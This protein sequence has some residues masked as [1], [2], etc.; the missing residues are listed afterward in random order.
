MIFRSKRETARWAVFLAALVC[1]MSAWSEEILVINAA[2]NKA[3]CKSTSV[4]IGENQVKSELCVSQGSFSHDKYILKLN[5]EAA[6][7]GIDDQ[8]TSGIKSSYKGQQVM[9]LCPP[10]N[11]R[12][13]V[14]AEEI[15]KLVPSYSS[16]K[17]KE[18]A[19]LLAG[20]SMPIEVGRLCQ[21]TIENEAVMKVQVLFE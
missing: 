14:T 3:T 4:R 17:A 12:P 11:I 21:V 10:Q 7:Q 6:L 2:P 9:L 20:S 13:N 18:V 8:T 5:G 15:Q 16:D 1:S 19:E